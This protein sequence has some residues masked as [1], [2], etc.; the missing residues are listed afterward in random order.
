MLFNVIKLWRPNAKLERNC[1]PLDRWFRGQNSEDGFSLMETLIALAI[2]S[3]A[4]L[5]LFQSTSSMLSLSDRAVRA[6]EK[7]LDQ[8]LD[9]HSLRVLLSS[10]VPNW[11]ENSDEAFTG[12]GD[13]MRGVSSAALSE[14]IG[15]TPFI[16][17]LVPSANQQG[18]YDL[19]YEHVDNVKPKR[20]TLQKQ[21]KRGGVTWA[22]WSNLGV[23]TRFTYQGLDGRWY[24]KWPPDQIPVKPY[25]NDAQFIEPPVLPQ[26]IK[27]QGKDDRIYLI[28]AINRN[29]DLP[30]R[31]D[32]GRNEF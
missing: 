16:L 15:L 25:F 24:K 14:H 8:A 2:M 3:V 29:N 18:R 17:R 19:T 5:A 26:A 4:S 11:L 27:L 9:R 6:G 30:T 7:A 21:S 12:G 13:I 32:I 22:L 1:L 10:L 23:D 31:L 28:V 20:S